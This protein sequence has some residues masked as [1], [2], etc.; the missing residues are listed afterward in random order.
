MKVVDSSRCIS[1]VNSYL[2]IIFLTVAGSTWSSL[3]SPG[4]C[5]LDRFTS[6]RNQNSLLGLGH[7]YVGVEIRKVLI[8]S[9][10]FAGEDLDWRNIDL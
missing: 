6:D 3:R 5:F 9:L 8:F 4:C 7:S 1:D 2:I 10:V